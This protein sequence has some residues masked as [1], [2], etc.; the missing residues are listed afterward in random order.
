MEGHN[1]IMRNPLTT[2]LTA[3]VSLFIACRVISQ[4]HKELVLAGEPD[5]FKKIWAGAVYLGFMGLLLYLYLSCY[6]NLG[7]PGWLTLGGL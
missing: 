1:N 2:L 7:V 6:Y 5:L 3:L 4:I